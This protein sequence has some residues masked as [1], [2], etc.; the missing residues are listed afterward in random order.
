MVVYHWWVWVSSFVSLWAR[1]WARSWG[2]PHAAAHR[3]PETPEPGPDPPSVGCRGISRSNHP[4]EQDCY[5]SHPEYAPSL[6][7]RR[8]GMS[9]LQDVEW[10]QYHLY[11]YSRIAASNRIRSYFYKRL[12]LFLTGVY[13]WILFHFRS[14]IVSLPISSYFLF[15]NLILIVA[16]SVLYKYE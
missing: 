8:T 6:V 14:S 9:Y 12:I 1:C 2:D 16:N 5:H 10:I 15:F 11:G 3:C 7:W 4:P 13:F